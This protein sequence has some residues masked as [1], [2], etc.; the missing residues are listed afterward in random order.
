MQLQ[1]QE[2]TSTSQ[3]TGQNMKKTGGLEGSSNTGSNMGQ[4][5]GSAMENIKNKAKESMNMK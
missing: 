3:S 4:K 5:A 1:G 2:E